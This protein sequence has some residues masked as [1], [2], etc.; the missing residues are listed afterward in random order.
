MRETSDAW[1]LMLSEGNINVSEKTRNV[2]SI[3]IILLIHKK[4][5]KKKYLPSEG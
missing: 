4:A 5:G 1:L 3:I 2:Y